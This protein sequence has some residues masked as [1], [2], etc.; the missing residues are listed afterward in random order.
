MAKAV[1]LRPDACVHEDLLPSAWNT[2]YRIK[3]KLVGEE[4]LTLH[5]VPCDAGA[6]NLVYVFFTQSDNGEFRNV[7][8]AE[9]DTRHVDATDDAS[10]AKAVVGW[11]AVDMLVNPVWD[12][13][14]QTLTTFNRARGMGDAGDRGVW[15]FDGGQATLRY[16]E[17][18]FTLDG[19]YTP[20]VYFAAEGMAKLP[21]PQRD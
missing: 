20:T 21:P 10:V 6:Y 15:G 16:Y 5:G 17:R 2:K 18:D 7:G 9:P 14:A 12:D 13:A 4:R 3:A 8:F 19:R 1:T 11:L